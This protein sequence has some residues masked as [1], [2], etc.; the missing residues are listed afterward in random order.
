VFIQLSDPIFGY[1]F[2]YFIKHKDNINVIFDA[3]L[4]EASL[5]REFLINTILYLCDEFNHI[6]KTK[7]K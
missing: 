5:W 4:F 7:V 1:I 3:E 2:S 6:R